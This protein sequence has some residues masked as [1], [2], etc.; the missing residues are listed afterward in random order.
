MQALCLQS[1]VLMSYQVSDTQQYTRK[2]DTLAEWIYSERWKSTIS[3]VVF[4]FLV[5][6]P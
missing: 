3:E 5:R 1:D 6:D 4:Y 2:W